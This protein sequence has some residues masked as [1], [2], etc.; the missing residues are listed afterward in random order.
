MTP[1]ALAVRDA[2][3]EEPR[4]KEN[5]YWCN[6]QYHTADLVLLVS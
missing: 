5:N 3:F 1:F 4:A 6:K 2:G